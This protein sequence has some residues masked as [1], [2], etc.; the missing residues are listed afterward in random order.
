MERA[1]SRRN[2]STLP[3]HAAASP[4]PCVSDTSISSP[5]PRHQ[6]LA[7][8]EEPAVDTMHGG[9]GL[10]A[11]EEKGKHK[12]DATNPT[13]AGG[14]LR[15]AL[16]ASAAAA[17]IE[18]PPPSPPPPRLHALDDAAS[19]SEC[20][21]EGE[22][23]R[24]WDDAMCFAGGDG[25]SRRRPLGPSAAVPEIEELPPSPPP[26]R[27][28]APNA[29]AG[30]WP[31]GLESSMEDV[32]RIQ[33]RLAVLRSQLAQLRV[34][35]G[36]AGAGAGGGAAVGHGLG[37]MAEES[38]STRRDRLVALRL[39]AEEMETFRDSLKGKASAEEFWKPVRVP[40]RNNSKIGGT[41]NWKQIVFVTAF[42]SGLV[43]LIR[44]LL[45]VH[46]LTTHT[47]SAVGSMIFHIA[48][49][50]QLSGTSMTTKG[51]SRRVARFMCVCSLLL[52]LYVFYL[53]L[54][55]IG[56]C[57]SPSLASTPAFP[58]TIS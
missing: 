36:E 4:S 10:T 5:P 50:R 51:F 47:A 41:Y 26:S 49:F 22:P 21:E 11:E 35:N 27:L 3:Q 24:A 28:P 16:F 30:V 9:G 20:L 34:G 37:M 6:T 38:L 2:S 23:R 58:S 52:A 1:R 45:P 7:A 8:E 42:I 57:A 39:Q 54:R 56:A 40:H 53:D 33:A 19:S 44:A 25:A 32:R 18:A 43:L 46:Y 13:V 12:S 14:G 17:E 15:R 48:I 55:L 29:A 31:E